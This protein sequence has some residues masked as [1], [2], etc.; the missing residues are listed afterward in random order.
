MAS[1][2]CHFLCIADAWMAEDGIAG[3]LIPSGFMDVNYGQ[4]VKDYLLNKVTLLRVHRF[5]PNDVQFDDALVSSAIVWFQ[6][7][8]PSKNHTVEFSYGGSLTTPNE[9][10]YIS[11]EIL[12]NIAKWTTTN[13]TS[14]AINFNL[15]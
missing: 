12:H 13:S 1:L 14:E 5:C 8:L 15:Q 9:R 6:K 2:Y 11:S 4:Q 3:W 7:T 10:K